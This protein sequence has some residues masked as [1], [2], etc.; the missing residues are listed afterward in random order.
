MSA[1]HRYISLTA[2]Q[3]KEL[4]D[5]YKTGKKAT[6][7][8]RC[9]L[10]LLSDKGKTIDEIAEIMDFTRQT[11]GNWFSRFEEFGCQGLHTSKGGGRPPIFR[12]DNQ[13]EIERI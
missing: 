1:K 4:F 12:I 5:G 8:Q 7:R 10:I 11:V 9:H 3:R 6:Y 13:Q 2:P